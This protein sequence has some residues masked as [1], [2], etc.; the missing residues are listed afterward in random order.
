MIDRCK[1]RLARQNLSLICCD[2]SDIILSAKRSCQF[3]SQNG[4]FPFLVTGKAFIPPS[5]PGD[6]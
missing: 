1:V 2:E 4:H 3:G 6:T 5:L